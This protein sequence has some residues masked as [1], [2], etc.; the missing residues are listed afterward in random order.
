MPHE[1]RQGEPCS[2]GSRLWKRQWHSLLDSEE[3]VGVWLGARWV[4][5]VLFSYHS[6]CLKQLNCDSCTYLFIFSQILPYHTGEEH[7]WTSSLLFFSCCLILLYRWPENRTESKLL[8][9]DYS[10]YALEF[11]SYINILK[12]V[13]H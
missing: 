9:C 13:T 11:Y 6:I 3:L 10:V 7:V 5:V 12:Y 4:K 1:R 2:V 8:A